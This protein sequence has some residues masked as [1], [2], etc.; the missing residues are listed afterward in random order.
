MR[1]LAAILAGAAMWDIT[2]LDPR[3]DPRAAQR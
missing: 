1:N 2:Y 3:D